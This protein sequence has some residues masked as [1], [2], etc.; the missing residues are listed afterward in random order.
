MCRNEVIN[1]YRTTLTFESVEDPASHKYVTCLLIKFKSSDEN[2]RLVEV[3]DRFEPRITMIGRF[4]PGLRMPEG[5]SDSSNFPK[6]P[7]FALYKA[8]QRN[9]RGVNPG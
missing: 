6:T 4:H 9:V 1:D 2:K 8:G 3:N 5:H 7:V